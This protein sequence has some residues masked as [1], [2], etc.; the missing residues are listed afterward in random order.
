MYHLS[1]S[2]KRAP[3][4]SWG[5]LYLYPFFG[6]TREDS[7]PGY[8]FIPDG[9]GSL[10]QFASTTKA[11]NMFYG[12]FYGSDLGMVGTLP[13][14]PHAIRPYK[15]SIPVIGMVHGEKQ[16]AYIAI[17]EKGASY[18]EVQA[19]PAGVITNFNFL[20]TAFVY[21]ESYFQAT[22]RSGAGV[23]ALQH[24]T[25]ALMSGSTTGF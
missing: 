15:M 4:S 10:I 18:G 9:A 11:T 2:S 5:L 21:N 12:R 1:Q 23:T 14:D 22:N 13:Y 19:H 24:D 16:N 20:A 17:V 7:I 6:A 25:N 3:I 8:M